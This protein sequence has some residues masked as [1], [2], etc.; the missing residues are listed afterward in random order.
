MLRE[1][2]RI[3]NIPSE[4]VYFLLSSGGSAPY[5]QTGM[6]SLMNPEM[7][8]PQETR[9]RLYAENVAELLLNGLSLPR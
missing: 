8:A 4:V 2:G 9:V 3:K 5:S 6:A 7:T 1:Q